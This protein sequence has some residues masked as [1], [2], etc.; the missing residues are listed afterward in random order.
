M[1]SPDAEWRRSKPLSGCQM[2]S[3]AEHE[4]RGEAQRNASVRLSEIINGRRKLVSVD[5][6]SEITFD[7]GLFKDAAHLNGF[8]RDLALLG[9]AR[10][11][12]V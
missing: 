4:S 5:S 1:R 10:T 12:N 8:V 2:P 9:E 7:D 3:G 11:R 6:L